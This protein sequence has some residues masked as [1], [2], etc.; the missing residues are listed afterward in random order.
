MTELLI[1]RRFPCDLESGSL[2]PS[3]Y[4]AVRSSLKIKMNCDHWKEQAEG[5][6][7]LYVGRIEEVKHDVAPDLDPAFAG[8]CIC[9]Y[10]ARPKIDPLG[11]LTGGAG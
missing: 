5:P 3:Y 8:A 10:Q 9:V 11:K 2:D 6:F 7:D 4:Y 1:P